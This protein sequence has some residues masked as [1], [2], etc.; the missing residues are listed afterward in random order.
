MLAL[1]ALVCAALFAG[2]AL[3]VS[4]AEHPARMKLDDRAALTQWKPSYDR[5][6]ILQASL[7]ILGGVLGAAAWY[8]W[9]GNWFWL[10]GGFVLFLNVPYT[11]LVVWS[12]NGKLKAT[13]LDQAGPETRALLVKW[14]N[15]HFV[16]TLLG[17]LAAALIARG[18]LP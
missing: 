2:A 14:G 7:A 17:L 4:F 18:L 11:L 9:Q 12:T 15:L 8:R 1:A 13:E 3:Y 16:R 6:A 5:A 10:A